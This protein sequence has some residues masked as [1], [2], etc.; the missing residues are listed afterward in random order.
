MVTDLYYQAET[1]CCPK[2]FEGAPL[3]AP[4][5]VSNELQANGS[6]SE[7]TQN[8]RIQEAVIAG[9]NAE[10]V[11]FSEL[12]LDM[13]RIVQC[14]EREPGFVGADSKAIVQTPLNKS[15]ADVADQIGVAGK[16]AITAATKRPN[17][18]KFLLYLPT[19]SQLLLYIATAVKVCL[20][21]YQSK[22]HGS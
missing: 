17:P 9:N 18:H 11:K 4:I 7:T 6:Q 5:R 21:N 13:Y 3:V 19:I 22:I 2:N 16:P 20:F 15:A 12:S 14:L 1:V 10:Q 8:L